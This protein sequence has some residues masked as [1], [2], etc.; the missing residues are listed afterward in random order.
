MG[1]TYFITLNLHNRKSRLL[2][3][4]IDVLRQ[5]FVSVKQNRPF[6]ILAVVVFVVARVKLTICAR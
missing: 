6:E 2:T 4:N 3:E 1:G 5:A